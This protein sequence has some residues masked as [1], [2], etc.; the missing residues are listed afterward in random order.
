MALAIPVIV[1]SAGQEAKA[2]INFGTL[3]DLEMDQ[4]GKIKLK[5]IVIIDQED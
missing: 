2:I 5:K 1:S 4:I 3:E